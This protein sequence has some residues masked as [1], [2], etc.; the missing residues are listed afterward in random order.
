MF[1]MSLQLPWARLQKENLDLRFAVDSALE[2]LRERI[3]QVAALR[4]LLHK[5]ETQTIKYHD[6]WVVVDE[7]IKDTLKKL[8]AA[9]AN[10]DHRLLP[11]LASKTVLHHK[12]AADRVV[13]DQLLSVFEALQSAASRLPK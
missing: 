4:V 6:N 12:V 7:Q 5:Q 9:F 8:S 13:L 10:Y 11:H 1:K 2:S 3:D